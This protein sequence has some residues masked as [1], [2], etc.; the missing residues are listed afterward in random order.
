MTNLIISS[1]D[2]LSP[3]MLY[4]LYLSSNTQYLS[5]NTLYD[6]SILGY[7]LYNLYIISSP[8]V[9]IFGAAYPL[10]NAVVDMR[11][12]FFLKIQ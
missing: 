2:N 10:N 6:L 5:S 11:H 9:S 12:M 1:A 4:H 8:K 3:P 7:F